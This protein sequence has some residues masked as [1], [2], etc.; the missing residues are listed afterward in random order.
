MSNRIQEQ[1]DT[2]DVWVV[3]VTQWEELDVV[4]WLPSVEQELKYVNSKDIGM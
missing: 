3:Y 4:R 1:I 2:N